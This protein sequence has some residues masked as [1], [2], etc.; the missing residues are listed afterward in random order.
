MQGNFLQTVAIVSM[1]IA[2]TLAF[3]AHGS[4]KEGSKKL[5]ISNKQAS[6]KADWS[7]SR[8]SMKDI[9]VIVKS[10]HRVS[11]SDLQRRIKRLEEENKQIRTNNSVLSFELNDLKKVNGELRT[12]GERLKALSEQY[13][14]AV[15]QLAA[16]KA[17]LS[18]LE[19]TIADLRAQLAQLEQKEEENR[20]LR[21]NIAALEAEGAD[22]RAQIGSL[23]QT[24]N[25]LRA[26][27]SE[28]E[29]QVAIVEGIERK[30]H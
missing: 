16:L 14:A 22:L 4:L 30:H 18:D 11:R 10:K 9:A 24:I 2:S 17:Q 13:Q 5:I 27:I 6:K 29:A 1:I 23:N 26:K 21:A 7:H 20:Q 12:E 8:T 28:L 19:K 3:K 15:Q 25:E